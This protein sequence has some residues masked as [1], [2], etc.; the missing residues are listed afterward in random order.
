M[1][2][3]AVGDLSAA[4]TTPHDEMDVENEVDEVATK[5]AIIESLKV[6]G[7][8]RQPP[9]APPPGAPPRGKAARVAMFDGG[10]L[11]T[12][13]QWAW[14]VAD[15]MGLVIVIQT[16]GACP[17]LSNVSIGTNSELSFCLLGLWLSRLLR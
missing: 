17:M 7:T 2:R 13:W 16:T 10:D 15:A 12:L 1:A 6:P 4:P 14:Q 8:P 3:G 9:V 5:N 11:A